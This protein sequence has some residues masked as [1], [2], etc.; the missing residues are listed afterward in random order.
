MPVAIVISGARRIGAA[1]VRGLADAGYAIGLTY[2]SSAGEAE[3][4]ATE[5]HSSG[6]RCLTMACDV[7]NCKQLEAALIEFNRLLGPVDVVVYNTGVFPEPK[8]PSSVSEEEILEAFRINALPVLTVSRTYFEQCC[9]SDRQGRLIVLGSL[10]AREIWRNR[11][12]YNTSKAAQQTLTLSLARSLAP[13][14]CINI[15]APG[16]ISQPSDTHEIGSAVVSERR[17][18]MNR[19]GTPSDVVDAV[20]YFSRCSTYIT[21]QVLVVDGGYGLVR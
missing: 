4:L 15:V 13:Q 8:H 2:R 14:L 10:G 9:S 3:A 12:A 20:L 6:V 21:G 11:A 1:I 17:I 7:T 16:L 19:Q 18:P 5:L